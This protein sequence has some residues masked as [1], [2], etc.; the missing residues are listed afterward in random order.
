[1]ITSPSQRR[2]A[3]ILL[4]LASVLAVTACKAKDPAQPAGEAF[5]V[6]APAP[7]T[8]PTPS[9][10]APTNPAPTNSGPGALVALFPTTA[11]AYAT[12]VVA[13]WTQDHINTLG[14]LT[15][16]GVQEQLLEIPQPLDD[17][18][19]HLRCDGT[20]GSSYC[21]FANADGDQLTLRISHSLLGKPHA[22]IEVTLDLTEYPMD[23]LK[24]V[25]EFVGAWQIGNTA[26]M[27][28]LSKQSIV[29]QLGAAPVSPSYPA[30][31][32]CGGGLLQVTVNWSGSSVRFDVGTIL[33]G[34]PHA[35]VGYAPAGLD[36]T[37]K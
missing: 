37:W 9:G 36:L 7:S 34:G 12:A 11:K 19:S 1:M 32:C 33:L 27:L 29:D 10:P 2:R 6:V 26:R 24:Y 13:A 22:A 5:G 16:P 3:L 31:V 4:G 18:W 14:S 8:N 20:A 28:K 30:P 25:K 15:T 17:A 35:I 21:T 23:G